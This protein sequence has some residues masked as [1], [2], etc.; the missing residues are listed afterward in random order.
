MAKG[1]AFRRLAPPLLLLLIALAF[2]A[3]KSFSLHWEVGDENI[4]WYMARVMAEDGAWFYRDFFFAHPPLHLIPGVLLVKIF[5]FSVFLARLLPA[6]AVLLVGIFI[7]LS[8]RRFFGAAAGVAA[9]ACFLFSFDVLR[10]SSHWTGINLTTMWLAAGWWGFASGR[11]AT[12]G[13]LFALAAGTGNYAL[14][15]ALGAAVLALVE[16]R[17]SGLRF[18]A[19]FA[20]LWLAVQL[21]GLFLGGG[22]Y[23]DAVWRYHLQKPE[24]SVSSMFARAFTDNFFMPLCALLGV[25]FGWRRQESG[26]ASG[27]E[28]SGLR[29]FFDPRC[30]RGRT[31]QLALLV[32]LNLLFLSRLG[33]LFPF[34]FLLVFM[35]L[36]PPAGLGLKI[37]GERLLALGIKALRKKAPA[38]LELLATL[39][40]P[41]LLALAL[42]ARGPLQNALLPDY[43]R[44]ADRPMVWAEAPLPGPVN[45][46]LRYLFFE[47]PARAYKN[48]GTITEY[49]FHESQ[50]FEAAPQLAEYVSAHTKAGEQIFGDSSSAPLVAMLAGRRLAAHE[51]DTNAMRFRSGI[52]RPKE[53][54]EKVEKDGVKLVLASGREVRHPDGRIRY[55]F[56]GFGAVGEF[57]RWLE[58][59]FEL[60]YKVRDRTKGE[61]FIFSRRQ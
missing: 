9:A 33:R 22:G 17:R 42:L 58:E 7:Y 56:G 30:V 32:L 36:A 12:A 50:Y 37:M 52:T 48:Y 29:R 4:Y 2:L 46:M 5:G 35:W 14:P 49:L 23:I 31:A 54:I 13:L 47:N 3:L 34:Y 15:S 53:L 45:A 28:A 41:L 11:L 6:G 61:F 27:E 39:G 20:G 43:L 55:S 10:A 16:G 18:G 25:W 21:L 59:N 38:P 19:A 24:G 44:K 1:D 51:A 8:T 57:R 60:V 26:A 40:A